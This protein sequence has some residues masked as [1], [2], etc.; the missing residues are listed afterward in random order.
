M[1]T[2]KS[3]AIILFPFFLLLSSNLLNIDIIP[4]EQVCR[5]LVVEIVNRPDIFNK[6]KCHVHACLRKSF[7]LFP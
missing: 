5:R 1:H 7:V 3:V 2:I 6:R 4:V